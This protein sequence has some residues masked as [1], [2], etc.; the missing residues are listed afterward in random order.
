MRI[1]LLEDISGV[2]IHTKEILEEFGHKVE[3]FK[4]IDIAKEFFS[5]NYNNIDCLVIDLNMDDEFLGEYIAESNGG[6]ISGWV[7]LQRFVYPVRPNIPTVIYS[8]LIEE[9]EDIIDKTLYKNIEFVSKTGV[10]DGG[11]DGLISAI[12]RLEKLEG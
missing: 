7:F 10:I 9:L 6:E 12:N 5:K 2:R 3:D 11:T 1:L 4:R 8:G